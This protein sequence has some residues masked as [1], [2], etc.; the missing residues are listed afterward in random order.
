MAGKWGTDRFRTLLEML[1]GEQTVHII[2]NN[3]D[4]YR[5]EDMIV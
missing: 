3:V 1:E 4:L 2:N 5:A